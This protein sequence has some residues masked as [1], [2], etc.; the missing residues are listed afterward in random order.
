[1]ANLGRAHWQ[2]MKWIL[3]YLRGTPNL[4]L[5]FY[6]ETD[7]NSRVVGYFDADYDGDLD[8]RKSLTWYVFTL[9]GYAISWK[10][11][12]QS[13]IALSNIE[14]D[15]M[16]AAKAVKEAIWLKGLISDLGLQHDALLVFCDS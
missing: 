3:R 10:A 15:Y 12:L 16:A 5:I 2:T 8:K 11:I 1:M 4:G 9:C 14:A 13:T 7:C 6:R